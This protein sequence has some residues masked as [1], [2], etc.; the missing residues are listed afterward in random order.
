V[1]GR[2]ADASDLGE[3][4]GGGVGLVDPQ[5]IK[6]E[7]IFGEEKVKL[8]TGKPL[9]GPREGIK[10]QKTYRDEGWQEVFCL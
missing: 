2:R 8:T 1:N 5:I 9:G 3:R 4:I 7:G 10:I 6:N